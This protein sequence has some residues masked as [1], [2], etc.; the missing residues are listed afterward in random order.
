MP[1]TH[2]P[3]RAL[4]AIPLLL[5]AAAAL[6]ACGD[7]SS[8]SSGTTTTAGSKGASTTT[9]AGGGGGAAVS[10]ADTDLGQVL[11]DAEG[12]TLYAFTPDSATKSVCTGGCAQAWPPTVANG[13]PTAGDGVTAE[14]TVITRDDG[15]KQVA[16]DGHPLYQYAGDTAAGETTGQGSGG[17]WYV[18]SADGS[19]VKS[20]AGAPSSTTT[21]TGSRY[22][23]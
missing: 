2:R 22:G 1:R 4:L 7:D 17:T 20:E 23:Y 21:S 18:L 5:L 19:L 11:V 16:A 9:S 3:A 10:V 14:L 13:T 8:S 15:T 6:V 12:R